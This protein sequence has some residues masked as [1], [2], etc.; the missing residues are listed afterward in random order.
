MNP[1]FSMTRIAGIAAACLAV[2]VVV[3]GCGKKDNP[4][5]AQPAAKQAAVTAPP[6]TTQT[7]ATVTAP[8]DTISSMTAAQAR[9]EIARREMPYAEWAFLLYAQTG[10]LEAVRLFVT[11]GMD[12]ETKNPED[13]FTALHTAATY[14]HLA[15]V[16]YLVGQSATVDA[17]GKNGET[18]LMWAA[19]NG[20]LE[21]V[22]YL[23]GQGASLLA[24]TT[25]GDRAKD[26]AEQGGFTAVATYLQGLGEDNSDELA[27]L[28]ATVAALQS[29]ID[30]LEAAADGTTTITLVDTVEIA[31]VDTVHFCPPSDEDR[32]ALFDAFTGVNEDSTG[33]AGK[34][35]AA[36]RLESWGAIK[37]LMQE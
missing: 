8:P 13:D 20:H 10:N 34:A 23:V 4:M 29:E 35:A 17:K 14:G 11:A 26:L 7:E 5:A 9:A 18:P 16:E 31:R 30:A 21:I 6:D 1:F 12:L 27:Q 28:R 25:R 19:L 2:A 37:A 22:K 33:G 36:V 32:Q 3:A 24:E 15:V